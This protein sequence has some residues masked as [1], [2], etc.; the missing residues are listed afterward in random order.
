MRLTPSVEP[1][2]MS[3]FMLAVSCREE[4]PMLM[5]VS[6]LSP[7]RIHTFIPASRRLAIV[8][9]TPW[10]GYVAFHIKF[11]SILITHQ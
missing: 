10:G 8:L 5:A 6:C 2:M 1:L 7:V 9:G 11:H 4:K 3:S